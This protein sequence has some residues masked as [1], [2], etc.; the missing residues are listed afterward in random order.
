M[1]M[2][3]LYYKTENRQTRWASFENPLGLKGKSAMENG[4]AKGRA[5][6]RFEAKETKTLLDTDGPGVVDRIWLTIDKSSP[7]MLRSLKLEMFWDHEEKP[8]VSVPLPDFFCMMLGR[9]NKLETVFFSNPEGR[10]YNS[11]IKMPFLKHARIT[12]TN[13]SDTPLK[14]IFYDINYTLMPLD[15]DK[16]LYL[17]AFWNRE[18]PTQLTKDYT[19]LPKV[20][21]KGVFAGVNMSV[22]WDEKYAGAWF[23]E[24]EIKFYIDGDSEYPT[25]CGTGTE[26]YIG[27]AWGQGEFVNMTQ[28]CTIANKENRMYAF[29]RFH[30][31][32]PIYF[33][34]DIV[35]QIQSMGGEDK[36][37]LLKVMENGA[38]VKIVTSDVD[39]NLEHLFLKDFKLDQ[40][41]TDCWYNF[42]HEMDY[43][44]TAY[45]YLDKPS[46]NLPPLPDIQRRTEG[47]QDCAKDITTP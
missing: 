30:T 39:G 1:I 31:C 23:G 34:T 45:F 41:S 2:N 32:D 15:E 42:Y 6:K 12:L 3:E 43:T 44:S 13:E 35:A 8:A 20:T 26:D 28:G 24:G 7:E 33:D 40:N 17:H 36:Y 21:G 9:L 5:F 14:H 25:L 22:R 18:N 10:S 29:Y 46:S 37:G 4:G 11:F 16:T 27:T 38:P 47:L 19:I